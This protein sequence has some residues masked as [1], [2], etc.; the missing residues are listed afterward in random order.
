MIRDLLA[1]FVIIGLG[2]VLLSGSMLSHDISW[3]LIST[4]W[5]ID[6]LPI[7]EE[8]LELNPPLAFYLTAIPVWMSDLTGL[9]ADVAYKA[10]IFALILA[11]LMMSRA[12]LDRAPTVSALRRRI[13]LGVA[14]VGLVLLPIGDFGQRDH[15]FAIFFLPFLTM[16]MLD[17]SSSRAHRAVIAVWATLGIALKH[18]FLVLPLLV[19]LYKIVAAR[20]LRPVVRIEY[21]L[22]AVLLVAYV[23]ATALL[24][25]AYF[26]RVIPLTLQV[27]G[28][29]DL[30][31]AT[32]LMRAGSLILV[33]LLALALLALSRSRH[34]SSAIVTLVALGAVAI[35]FIQSKGWAYHRIPG[36]LYVVLA[37]AWVGAEMAE[38]RQS[39]LPAAVA[40]LGVGTL[41]IPA[42][43]DG[44]YESAFARQAATFF[45][46]P[47]GERS[48]QIFSSKVSTGFPLANLAQAEPANRAPTL[49]LFPGAT[50]MLAKTN[51][52]A[53][54]ARYRATQRAARDLVLS[55][56]FRARPQIVIVDTSV[57]KTHF[58][59]A[60]FDYLDYFRR[61]RPFA[62]AWQEYRL[63]GKI[64]AYDVYAREGC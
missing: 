30:P 63:Q 57:E 41:L 11:S 13:F 58:N 33:L 32:V 29:F 52:P 14:A 64:G 46:C 25:P 27:Y 7:Y 35:Y 1:P 16:S 9:S 5:W 10:F 53:E 60:E 23:G 55:D 47:A 38:A 12:E 45:T 49:W 2:V 20:S 37:I 39:W 24:H 42:L 50:H 4:R 21:V 44:P 59:G 36:T 3:Y 8:I 51:D 40:S 18:Y 54:Q 43:D 56:F 34:H 28:A 48:F 22:P 62:V 19:L 17:V 6:G 61:S 31:F 26:D 15:M